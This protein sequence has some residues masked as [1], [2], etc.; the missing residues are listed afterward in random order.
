MVDFPKIKVSA[1]DRIGEFQYYELS[2]IWA[3]KVLRTLPTPL[4][5]KA[6]RRKSAE[7][8][9]IRQKLG[10]N[11]NPNW[12]VAEAA[13]ILYARGAIDADKMDTNSAVDG[14]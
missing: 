6:T 9:E 8:E 12:L 13:E 7:H 2:T 4:L 10:K 1:K 11:T 14:E 3:V 5:K